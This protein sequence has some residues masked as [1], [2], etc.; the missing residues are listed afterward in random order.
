MNDKFW[1]ND[2]LI[3]TK[4]Y[5]HFF[6]TSKMT[7]NEQL[8]SLSLFFIYYIILL[9][10]LQKEQHFYYIPIVGIIFII[11]LFYV[12]EK[13]N[14][15]T[16]TETKNNIPKETLYDS[17]GN[18]IDIQS[19]YYDSNNKLIIGQSS[20]TDRDK[21]QKCRTPTE[22]NPFMNPLVSE[23]GN[24][25]IPAACNVDDENIKKD[26][27]TGFNKDLYRD[28]NDVFGKKNSER[29]Y[30]TLPEFNPKKFADWCYKESEY[31]TCKTNNDACLRE[32]DIRFKYVRR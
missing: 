23:Y 2:P 5:L 10:I 9:I 31:E 8:N 26:I 4:N 15:K 30:Y 7:R 1:L 18:I 25:N 14:V 27:N 12:N 32:E 11:V 6:P 29:N 17:S 3:L 16:F 22:N 13:D 19:G 21:E 24:G 20:P 28:V